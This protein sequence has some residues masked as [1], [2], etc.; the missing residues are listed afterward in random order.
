MRFIKVEILHKDRPAFPESRDVLIRKIIHR[1]GDKTSENFMELCKLLWGLGGSCKNMSSP[2]F[3]FTLISILYKVS[4]TSS[5]VSTIVLIIS[6]MTNCTTVYPLRCLPL[7]VL[8]QSL[9]VHLL[10]TQMTNHSVG[11]T[12]PKAAAQKMHRLITS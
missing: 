6:V 9:K 1:G 2:V 8:Q 4:R 3:P 10:P 11:R 5:V 7:A 12:F